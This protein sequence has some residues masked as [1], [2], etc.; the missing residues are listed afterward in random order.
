MAEELRPAL[1]TQIM[2][3]HYEA[4]VIALQEHRQR[5]PRNLTISKAIE[6][7]EDAGASKLLHELGPTSCEVIVVGS[8]ARNPVSP[9]FAALLR[10]ARQAATLGELLDKT[11]LGRFRTLQLVTQLVQDGMLALRSPARATGFG[12]GTLSTPSFEAI[13][14]R[15][16]SDVHEART[17]SSPRVDPQADSKVSDLLEAAPDSLPSVMD[18][19]TL[20]DPP[21]SLEPPASSQPTLLALLD[22]LEGEAAEKR[23]GKSGPDPTAS[24]KVATDGD[25]SGSYEPPQAATE[26]DSVPPEVARSS[27]PPDDDDLPPSGRPPRRATPEVAAELKRL[28]PREIQETDREGG[29]RIPTLVLA[30]IAVFA[31]SVSLYV[32]LGAKP[33]PTPPT[34]PPEART[35]PASP[36]PSPT[37]RP[38]A[39]PTIPSTERAASEPP[40]VPEGVNLEVEVSPPYAQVYLDG[41]LLTKPFTVLLARDTREHELRVE[42]G[43]HKTQRRTFV[44]KGDRSFVIALEPIVGKKPDGAPPEPTYD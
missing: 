9:N 16:S 26:Q 23:P 14:R 39:V 4:A 11:P 44:M 15:M 13:A 43:G 24:A 2:C 31:S 41:T 10:L 40:V 22:R 19:M 7:A 38:S 34:P 36:V 17:P 21:V 28:R 27:S 8:E 25:R 35:A 32:T 37:S 6:L 33:D 18:R 1:F 12:V 30:G 20:P 5:F 29:V 3:G 42:A